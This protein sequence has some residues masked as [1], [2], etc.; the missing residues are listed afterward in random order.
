MLAWLEIHIEALGKKMLYTIYL[1]IHSICKFICI[2]YR[3][4]SRYI[5]KITNK[6]KNAFCFGLQIKLFKRFTF[7]DF[8]F[9]N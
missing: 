4:A 1:F 9:F 8:F 5:L 2:F 6:N 3:T 7:V